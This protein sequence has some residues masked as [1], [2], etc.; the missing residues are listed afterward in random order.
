MHY[1]LEVLA[2]MPIDNALLCTLLI[3]CRSKL[4]S[5]CFSQSLGSHLNVFLN[6]QYIFFV[7]TS[8]L[9]VH[10]GNVT[11]NLPPQN[12]QVS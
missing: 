9:C 3:R 1:I 7:E 12:F 8:L 4:V 5:A 11:A 10:K 6:K 2:V